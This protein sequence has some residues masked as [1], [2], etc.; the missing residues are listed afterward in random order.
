MDLMTKP[1]ENCVRRIILLACDTDFVPV[2][3]S[4]RQGG[5]KITLFYYND[6]KR[7][8]KF[9]MSNHILTACD[10]YNLLTKDHLDRSVKS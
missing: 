10:E 6:F 3:N 8:S 2:L 4:L 9:S 1:R 5:I 7:N